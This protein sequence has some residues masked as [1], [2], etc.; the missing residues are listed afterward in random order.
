ML[1]DDTNREFF[2]DRKVYVPTMVN[3]HKNY[4]YCHKGCTGKLKFCVSV[5]QTHF[6]GQPIRSIHL[7]EFLIKNSSDFGVD[8]WVRLTHFLIGVIFTTSTTH[9]L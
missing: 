7:R 8:F 2:E 4:F 6:L 3:I 9:C 1:T 5:T